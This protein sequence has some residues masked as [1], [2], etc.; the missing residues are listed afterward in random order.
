MR[1]TFLAVAALFLLAFPAA[2]KQN[3]AETSG[4]DKPPAFVFLDPS[5]PVFSDS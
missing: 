5:V 1:R 4:S 3:S 2:A